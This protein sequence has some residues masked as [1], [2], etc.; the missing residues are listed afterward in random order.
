MASSLYSNQYRWLRGQ[1]VRA[2]K[3]KGLTQA[4][5]GR[6]LGVGQSQIS[7]MERGEAFIDVLTFVAWCRCVGLE[8]AAL[9]A[10]LPAPSGE[11]ASS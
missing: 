6:S 10:S 7:K 2:R 4:V 9:L 8:P 1:L 3:A 5:V 11:G